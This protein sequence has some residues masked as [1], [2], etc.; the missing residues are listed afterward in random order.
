[1]ACGRGRPILRANLQIDDV[2]RTTNA[3]APPTR[4]QTKAGTY[5]LS[6]TVENVRCFGPAQ[7]LDLSDGHGRHARWT[8]ILG[9][10]GLGKTT[11]LTCLAYFASAASAF[12]YRVD[13]SEV[14]RSYV[15]E[16][17]SGVGT[18]LRG[19][20]DDQGKLEALIGLSNRSRKATQ[21]EIRVQRSGL[22]MNLA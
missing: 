17:I 5:F 19:S 20:G 1:L 7:E 4:D 2:M 22:V 8:V 16:W 15:G 21:A 3:A 10:N 12:G 18:L 9:E 14:P 13:Q 11:L 6:L